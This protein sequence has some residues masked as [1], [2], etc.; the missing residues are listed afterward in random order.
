MDRETYRKRD[1]KKG[2]QTT[3]TLKTVGRQTH[4]QVRIGRIRNILV[5]KVW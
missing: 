2:W 1:I 5:Q 3:T 4:I